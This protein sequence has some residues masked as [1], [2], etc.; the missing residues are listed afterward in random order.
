LVP[1]PNRFRNS[2]PPS[3]KTSFAG[4]VEHLSGLQALQVLR[5]HVEGAGLL[6]V[7][8]VAGAEDEL[9]WAAMR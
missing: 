2:F 6:A 1:V 8:Q 5:Q 3:A 9:V 7:A 4:H